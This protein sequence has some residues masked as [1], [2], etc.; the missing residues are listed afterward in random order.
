[1][2]S[3]SIQNS[4]LHGQ[5]NT[6]VIQVNKIYGKDKFN[7]LN[8]SFKITKNFYRMGQNSPQINYQEK[9]KEESPLSHVHTEFIPG[10]P[11]FP[12]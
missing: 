5:K 11:D 8:D 12:N 4:Q 7:E 3:I 9:K 1:M 2:A 10:S 6:R